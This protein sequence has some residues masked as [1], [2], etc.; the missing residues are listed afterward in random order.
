MTRWGVEP[1]R[2]APGRQG[3][4][5]L[6]CENL[7]DARAPARWASEYARPAGIAGT[8]LSPEIVRRLLSLLNFENPSPKIIKHHLG[9][10]SQTG[11]SITQ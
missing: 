8:Q 3:P 6:C 1:L 10:I 5:W 7:S 2:P 9:G 11:A 4:A